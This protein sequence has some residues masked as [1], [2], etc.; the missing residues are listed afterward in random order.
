ML[1]TERKQLP[2]RF[3]EGLGMGASKAKHQSI[4]KP[5]KQF[6]PL[7]QR[8]ELNFYTSEAN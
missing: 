8:S 4:I 2:S 7:N 3:G 6:K 5:A 1:E